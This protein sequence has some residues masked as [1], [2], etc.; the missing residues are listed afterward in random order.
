MQ[1][2]NIKIFL[3]ILI[4]PKPDYLPMQCNIC[5]HDLIHLSLFL[6]TSV[7]NLMAH[8]LKPFNVQ[9]NTKALSDSILLHPLPMRRK[10]KIWIWWICDITTEQSAKF[11]IL[12]FQMKRKI[13]SV[14]VYKIRLQTH[15]TS[16]N[17]PKYFLSQTIFYQIQFQI[18]FLFQLSS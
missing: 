17:V 3:P 14:R 12:L 9:L 16:Q 8:L 5:T 11:G 18:N 13:W 10:L 1:H 4:L 2:L 15:I 6:S 7:F